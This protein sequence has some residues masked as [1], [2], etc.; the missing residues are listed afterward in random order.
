MNLLFWR[1]PRIPVLELHGTLST[2]PADLNIKTVGPAI[3][4]AVALARRSKHLVLDIASPGGSPVQS[5]LITSLLRRRAEE[6]GVKIHA[7]IGEVG[8][9]GGYWLACAADAIHANPMSVVGSIGVIGGSFGLNELIARYGVER[10]LYTAGENKARLDPF[11]PERPQDVEFVKR[12]MED[13]HARFKSWV[14]A[15]R[16]AKLIGDEATV[17]DG[18]WFL[19]DQALALGLIDGLADLD[20][21]VHDI[22]GKGVRM[23]VI[24]PQRRRGLLSRIP[25]LMVDATFDAI[26]DRTARINLRL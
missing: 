2:R 24:R 7:V 18:S 25:R 23:R 9:S 5:D 26:E 22:G 21:L 12:L 13:I 14:R 19:G 16:G 20:T 6:A 3:E 15:R 11:S 10:R 8:A 1:R 4:R 17:F